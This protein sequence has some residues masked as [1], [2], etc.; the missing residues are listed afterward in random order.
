VNEEAFT[1]TCKVLGKVLVSATA[2]ECLRSGLIE[3]VSQLIACATPTTEES[4]EDSNSC[5]VTVPAAKAYITRVRILIE[6]LSVKVNDKLPFKEFLALCHD[7]LI[8][9]EPSLINSD[10]R[11]DHN[12]HEAALHQ[13]SRPQTINLIYDKDSKYCTQE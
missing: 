2:H 13:L 12:R 11:Q 3:A 6:A 1:T 10:E 7:V 9:A 8:A 4:K 5:V